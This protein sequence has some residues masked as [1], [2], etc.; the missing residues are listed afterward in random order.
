MAIS[1]ED[2]FAAL[3]TI[4]QTKKL[5]EPEKQE[6]AESK[7]IDA[8]RQKPVPLPKPAK[9]PNLT[10][11]A[12][13]LAKIHDVPLLCEVVARGFD[14]CPIGTP[15][16]KAA[17]EAAFYA[18]KPWGEGRDL[19]RECASVFSNVLVVEHGGP[20]PF[21]KPDKIARGRE[22]ARRMRAAGAFMERVIPVVL[23]QQADRD[24]VS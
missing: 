19:A 9:P 4:I 13:T 15:L 16:G 6:T 14:E 11:E 20:P 24:F 3:K 23:A 18:V 12:K 17:H 1:D 22:A 8:P 2:I 7:A 10:N 21:G 5:P